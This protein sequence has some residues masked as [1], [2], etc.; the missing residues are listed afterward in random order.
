[1]LFGS[2][3]K[4]CLHC[5]SIMACEFAY[6]K[7]TDTVIVDFI[8]GGANPIFADSL[9]HL[10]YTKTYLKWVKL[11]VSFDYCNEGSTFIIYRDC[12]RIK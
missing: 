8:E 5:N 9:W 2:C 7:G 12:Y 1:M 3:Q 11:P 4:K 10:G 6:I